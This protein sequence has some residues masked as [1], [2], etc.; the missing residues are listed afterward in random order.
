MRANGRGGL[1]EQVYDYVKRQLFES[2]YRGGDRLPID[3]IAE[4]CSVSRQPVLDCMKRL[5]VDG[6]VLIVPQVGCLVRKYE[7]QEIQDFYR[8]L[9]DGEG[10][11]AE[12]ATQRA[13]REDLIVLRGISNQIGNLTTQ[14]L[15]SVELARMYRVINRVFHSEI[16]RMAQSPSLT[17]VVER[18]GDRSD[19][20]IA[21]SGRPFFG[22]TLASAHAEHEEL[23]LAMERRD[24]AGAAAAIREHIHATS[25]RLRAYLA[26]QD[27]SA[28]SSIPS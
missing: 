17:E 22:E 20:F 3:E 18:M 9:V 23:M 4:A 12:L 28:A 16:R 5:A 6:F 1:T 19:F 21:M 27:A 2:V 25:L 15:S 13:S 10:L 8:L 24:S 7:T 26:P 14:S 11:A